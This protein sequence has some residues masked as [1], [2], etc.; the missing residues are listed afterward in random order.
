MNRKL[1]II[2]LLCAILFAG[3]DSTGVKNV[4]TD[5]TYYT[6][7]AWPP[8]N[9]GLFRFDDAERETT[10][11]VYRSGAGVALWCGEMQR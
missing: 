2:V 1:A 10:C 6:H 7:L 3:C 4:M 5:E 11:Y 9:G 8:D